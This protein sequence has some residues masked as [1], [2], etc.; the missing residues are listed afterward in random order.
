MSCRHCKGGSARDTIG[1]MDALVWFRRDLRADDH[2]ALSQALQSANRVWCAFVLDTEIL[3]ALANRADRRVEFIQGALRE[4]HQ[5]LRERA[6]QAGLIVLHGAAREVLPALA[7][8]LGA[9]VVHANR[10]YEPQAVARDDD[11]ARALSASGRRLQLHL[12]QSIFPPEAFQ[13]GAGKRYTVF[14]PFR[15]AWLKRLQASD[16]APHTVPVCATALAAVPARESL[17]GGPWRDAWIG[18]PALESIGFEV[19]NLSTLGVNPGASG[20]Q[21]LLADFLSRIDDYHRK[22]DFPAVRGPS[23]LSVHLRFGTISI[24]QLARAAIE[25]ARANP[26]AADGPNAW[27]AEL[28]WREFYFQILTHWPHVRERAFRP[29]YDRI[30]FDT[31]AAAESRWHAWTEARTGYPLV[32]AAQRQILHSGWMHNRLRMVTASFLVKDLGIDWRRGEQ[33]F[34]QHLL[35]FDLAANNGGWQWASS[36]GCDAQPYF[37]IFNPIT[38]STKF[39]PEGHFIRRYVPELAKLPNRVLHAPWLAPASE[40][41]RAGVELGVNYP[42]P[43]VDHAV[44][45]LRTLERYAVVRTAAPAA[46]D[47]ISTNSKSAF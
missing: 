35:D 18:P 7:Q 16:L 47:Q 5:T 36:S 20:A 1:G 46:D 3:D 29:E 27:L 28:I 4:L 33:W 41:Q 26:A 19:T 11:I 31:D 2:A 6:S 39:D 40:L 43:I 15:N 25:R 42:R 8:R 9:A 21:R 17:A 12:D 34:A 14:S 10:D 44:A 30:E 32:D 13:T 22:R 23:Y 38:Q 24:R 37:R 45:R